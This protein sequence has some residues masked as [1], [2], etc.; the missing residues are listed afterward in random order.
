MCELVWVLS[1]TYGFDR[2]QIAVTLKQV[3]AARQLVFDATDRTSHALDAL[4]AGSGDLADYVN[5]EHAK[6][7]GCDGVVTFDKAL[8]TETFFRAPGAS[9]R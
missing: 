4:E 2:K 7:A 5:L 6:A 9:D 1:A 3:L 8:L